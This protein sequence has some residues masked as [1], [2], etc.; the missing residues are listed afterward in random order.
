MNYSAIVTMLTFVIYSS[1]GQAAVLITDQEAQL[2]AE[3]PATSLVTGADHGTVTRRPDM[4]FESPEG[5]VVSPFPFRITFKPHN[6]ARVDP[7]S[8]TVTLLTKPEVNLTNRLRPYISVSG[9]NLAQ[10]ETP[11][12]KFSLRIT[13]GDSAGNLGTYVIA[14]QVKRP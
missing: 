3:T 9:V 8:V 13:C 14:L 12:G 5:V 1:S 4:S 10:A 11:P 6:G 2:P 7:D